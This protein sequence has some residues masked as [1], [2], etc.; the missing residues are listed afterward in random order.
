MTAAP[1]APPPSEEMLRV[2]TAL[3][4]CSG[5]VADS[6]R[7]F[8]AM[9]VRALADQDQRTRRECEAKLDDMR[10]LLAL[11]SVASRAA[12]NAALARLAEADAVIA[13]GTLYK[14]YKERNEALARHASRAKE[15]QG[16]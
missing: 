5:L 2:S 14:Y 11:S 6:K 12:L 16:R 8:A 3:A 9:I 1:T 4:E 13:E 15:A 10:K 7:T